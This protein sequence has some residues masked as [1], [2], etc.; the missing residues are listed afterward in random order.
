MFNVTGKVESMA[1]NPFQVSQALRDLAEQ[2]TKHADAVYEQLNDFVT[3]AIGAWT[4][5]LPSSPV[6]AGFRD[7]QGRAV[8]I[9]RENVESAFTLA[10]KLTK[11]QNFPEILT[12]QRKY[13]QDRIQT[14][15][16][17]TQE[18]SK[19]MGEAFQKSAH[20]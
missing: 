6:A 12:L 19:L 16:T 9:A 17:Q 8:Q 4:S 14:F 18:L 7:L 1:D 2:N 20:H 3:K 15:V 11:V 10:E 13:A 5:A